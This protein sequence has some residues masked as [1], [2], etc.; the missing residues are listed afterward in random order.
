MSLDP[1]AIAAILEVLIPFLMNCFAGGKSEEELLE[2]L[3][4]PTRRQRFVLLFA[5]RHKHRVK[6]RIYY[7]ENPRIEEDA[8]VDIVRMVVEEAA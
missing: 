5:L 4:N 8:A 2:I 3:R 6:L 1:E 7:R